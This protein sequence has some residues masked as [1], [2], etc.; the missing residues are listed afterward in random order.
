VTDQPKLP[1]NNPKTAVG[2]L[3]PPVR[4]IPPSAIIALGLAMENGELK[5]GLMNWRERDV[6]SSVYYDAA[7]RH[8]MSWWDGEDKASDSKVHHLAH[9]MACCAILIDA[10]INGNLHDDR[11]TPGPVAEM[12]TTIWNDRTAALAT[13]LVLAQGETPAQTAANGG[14]TYT[15]ENPI[16]LNHA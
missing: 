3:K 2:R 1:D 15:P 8:L 11:P 10:E 14:Y 9:V 5:Y 13:E 4:A 16:D 7:M 6:S 12:I